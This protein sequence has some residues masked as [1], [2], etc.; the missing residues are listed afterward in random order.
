MPTMETTRL[1]IRSTRE[2]DGPACL[3]IWLDDEMGKYLSD[4]PRDKA[5]AAELNFA[6]GIEN[7]KGWYPMVVFH[8]ESGDF[9][10]TVSVVPSRDGTVWDLGYAV[11]KKYWRQG[12]ATEILKKIIEVGK[13]QGIRTF[14]ADVA[15]DNDASSAVLRKLNF[16]IVNDTET[17]RKRNTEIVYPKYTYLLTL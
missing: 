17:F 8:K 10:G 11:H 3:T 5:D 9:L 14:T 7:S 16:H 13:D 12:Y 1:L 6:V 2:E 15:K 4:P